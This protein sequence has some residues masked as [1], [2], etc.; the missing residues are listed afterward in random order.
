MKIKKMHEKR[1]FEIK[2]EEHNATFEAASNELQ[3]VS[4]RCCSYVCPIC[5]DVHLV[6]MSKIS[7]IDY[8]RHDVDLNDPSLPV[9]IIKKAAK[10][11]SKMV[12]DVRKIKKHFET[13][14]PEGHKIT[15]HPVATPPEDML[16]LVPSENLPEELKDKADK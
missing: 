4:K 7:Q 2:C 14:K 11:T 12:K 6:S 8:Y 3:F 5:G 10:R 1:T 16:P 13:M 9:N 15:T